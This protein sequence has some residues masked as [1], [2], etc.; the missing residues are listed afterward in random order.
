MTN[1]DYIQLDF[2]FDAVRMCVRTHVRIVFAH[3]PCVYMLLT[4]TQRQ[5]NLLPYVRITDPLQLQ[6]SND[7]QA[8]SF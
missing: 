3:V 1:V 7:A 6:S 8:L 4:G 5:S 2:S